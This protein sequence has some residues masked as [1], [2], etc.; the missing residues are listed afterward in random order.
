MATEQDHVWA[1]LDDM[2]VFLAKRHVPTP[3]RTYKLDGGWTLAMDDLRNFIDRLIAERDALKQ[4]LAAAVERAERAEEHIEKQADLLETIEDWLK[5]GQ[6]LGSLIKVCRF[7]GTRVYRS[8]WQPGHDDN[9][10]VNKIKELK[11]SA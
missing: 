5:T 8:G 4:Q 1:M 3:E 10:P 9:C 11:E 2:Q 6:E 7:C